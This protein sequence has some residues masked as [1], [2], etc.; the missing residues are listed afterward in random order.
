MGLKK[1]GTDVTAPRL[2]VVKIPRMAH[3]NSSIQLLCWEGAPGDHWGQ[4]VKVVTDTLHS[5]LCS[6]RCLLSCEGINT[7]LFTWSRCTSWAAADPRML[8]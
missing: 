1:T 4:C 5:R 8:N 7:F 3:G 2:R 6:Q